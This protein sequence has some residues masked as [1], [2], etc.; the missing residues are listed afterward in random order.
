MQSIDL[1]PMQ[2]VGPFSA[3]FKN[4]ANLPETLDILLMYIEGNSKANR[5]DLLFP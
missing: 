4:Y 2:K 5:S 3:C 1:Y